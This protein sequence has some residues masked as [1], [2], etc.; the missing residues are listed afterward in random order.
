M[1]DDNKKRMEFVDDLLA[2]AKQYGYTIKDIEEILG[3]IKTN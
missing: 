1:C 3:I 2:L